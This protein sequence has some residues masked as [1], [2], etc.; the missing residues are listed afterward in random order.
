MMDTAYSGYKP[1]RVV[2]YGL[3][4]CPQGSL[5]SAVGLSTTTVHGPLACSAV[6]DFERA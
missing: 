4:G 1:T 6:T 5:A 2:V 3:D